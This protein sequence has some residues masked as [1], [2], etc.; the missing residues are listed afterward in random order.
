VRMSLLYCLYNVHEPSS[1][2]PKLGIVIKKNNGVIVILIA[3][4]LVRWLLQKNEGME[5][6]GMF[7]HVMYCHFMFWAVHGRMNYK[8]TEPY[9]SAFL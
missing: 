8:D 6:S 2:L 1:S 7:Y 5:A 4:V 9:M 3:E